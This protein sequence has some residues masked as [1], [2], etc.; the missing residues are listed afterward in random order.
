MMRSLTLRT[1][2]LGLTMRSK[3][4][5]SSA[6]DGVFK[7]NEM[8][9]FRF[10]AHLDAGRSTA[11]LEDTVSSR[12]GRSS[13]VTG[14]GFMASSWLKAVTQPFSIENDL[15][16][17]RKSWSCSSRPKAFKAWLVVMP[18]WLQYKR[19]SSL[20]VKARVCNNSRSCWIKA[21]SDALATKSKEL[22]S[23]TPQST[24]R[25]PSPS[26]LPSRMRLVSGNGIGSS[27]RTRSF[28]LETVST[29]PTTRSRVLPALAADCFSA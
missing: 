11:S 22:P 4:V 12:I 19:L 23:L 7:I 1:V 9:T 16:L 25:C 20:G 2:S 13:L 24:S 5:T 14:V 8:S 21:S 26:T 6:L 15:C 18:C 29:G 10:R 27:I 28:K 3:V 17:S